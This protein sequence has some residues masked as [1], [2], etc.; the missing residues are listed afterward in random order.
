MDFRVIN[1]TLPSNTTLGT[2]CD[3]GAGAKTVYL[4]LGTM[5]TGAQIRILAAEALGGTY[6][7]VHRPLINVTATSAIP[8]IFQFVTATS[9]GMHPLPEGL[10][11]VKIQISTL[12]SDTTCTMRFISKIY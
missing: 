5:A 7:P 11:F 10:R 1:A 3:L 8:E 12:V 6:L 4:Q 9:A 2:A